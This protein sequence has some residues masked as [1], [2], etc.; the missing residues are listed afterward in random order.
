ML[1]RVT[2][3]GLSGVSSI[4]FLLLLC[5]QGNHCLL[6]GAHVSLP[7]TRHCLAAVKDYKLYTAC[8]HTKYI[9]FAL[10]YI[11]QS[12]VITHSYIMAVRVLPNSTMRA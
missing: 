5:S 3:I 11:F 2:F 6:D 9:I 7:V 1:D 12:S 8:M 4:V 10:Y